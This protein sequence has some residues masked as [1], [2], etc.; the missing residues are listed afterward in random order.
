MAHAQKPYFVF[1]RNGRVLLYRRERQFSRL[2]AAE[3]CASAVVMLDTPSSVVAWRV[4]AT[5]SIRQF[6]LHFSSRASPCAITFQ[7]ESTTDAV[8]SK[9]LIAS[10]IKTFCFSVCLCRLG[11]WLQKYTAWHLVIVY[12]R[13]A[14]RLDRQW[15]LTGVWYRVATWWPLCHCE[16]KTHIWGFGSTWYWRFLRHFLLCWP[17]SVS[18]HPFATG[19]AGKQRVSHSH[20]ANFPCL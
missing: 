4:L 6:L 18:K 20:E 2:L 19:Q 3:V 7:L 5:H 9:Q 13:S 10:L 16:A 11:H 12:R 14:A 17:I 8:W 1:R 15:V